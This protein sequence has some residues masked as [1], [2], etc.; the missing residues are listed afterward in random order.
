[1]EIS[2]KIGQKNI[3]CQDLISL[4]CE[5]QLFSSLA[6]EVIISQA[7]ADLEY[8]EKEKELA[9]NQFFLQ[10]QLKNSKAVELYCQQNWLSSEQ[11]DNRIKQIFLLEKFKVITWSKDLNTEFLQQKDRL[12]RAIYSLIRTKDSGIA[13]ELYFRLIENE[14]TFSE[15]ATRYSI[16][17]EANTGGLVGPIELGTIHPTLAKVIASSKPGI[18]QTPLSLEDWFVIVRLEKFIPAQLNKAT[19]KRLL[20][21]LFE[22]WLKQELLTQVS[23]ESHQ[24]G[25]QVNNS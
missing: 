14:A 16:G 18:V 25:T 7:I 3:K 9:T 22:N 12:D 6:K 19:E 10:H 13:Q 11:L 1:M 21:R 17:P 23:L 24:S 2:F 20:D 5:Y 4:L 8:S 15:L